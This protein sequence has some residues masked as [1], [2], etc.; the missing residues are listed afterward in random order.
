MRKA[1]EIAP[2]RRGSSFR[3]DV[4]RLASGT[5]IAQAISILAAPVITRLYSPQ[6]FGVAATFISITAL[7]GVIACLR[8][9]LSIVL[10]KD[11]HDAANLVA[12]SMLASLL[13][14]AI[15]SVG[16]W[17]GGESLS[18]IMPIPEVGAFL[19]LVPISVALSGANLSLNYWNSRTHNY[20]RLSVAK[21]LGSVC[22]TS[23]Q[24]G[25]GATGYASGGSMIAANLGGQ[26]VA[27]AWLSSWVLKAD[28]RFF[29]NSVS[30]R[31]IGRCAIRY[32]KF[33]LLSTWSGVL[34][35]ASWQ[36][37]VLM[38]GYF[39]SPVVVG[40][41]ALGF[42]LLQIPMNLMGGAVSQVFLQRAG[43]M[44]TSDG[45]A[46]LVE[47]MF[48]RLLTVGMFPML[49]LCFAGR[50]IYLVVFGDMWAEAGTYVQLLSAWAL[51][52]FVSSPLARLF[53]VLEK[54]EL[55]LAL[56]VSI[57]LTRLVSLLIGGYFESIYLALSLF[58]A[59]GFLLYGVQIIFVF[60]SVGIPVIRIWKY[61]LRNLVY[62][63]PL[64]VVLA[65]L[66]LLDAASWIV[67][68]ISGI[69]L[70][71]FGAWVLK[72]EIGVNPANR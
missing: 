25:L 44:R 22:T 54:H 42:R 9:E 69:A 8:Y 39:F 26:T 49:T 61:V 50:D 20:F 37:P 59:T 70:L 63:S 24:V 32:G 48:R 29:L 33:P 51:V 17:I 16:I 11:D 62:F 23:T 55:S 27:M 47:G 41:Y 10:P 19:W 65:V 53:F 21:V 3:G 71:I 68:S 2:R 60:R 14:S 18:R 15:S 43:E 40:Y 66:V 67:V 35:T 57:F 7:L 30:W 38:L 72:E 1:P 64:G 52:W 12:V 58:A 28:G 56:N 31:S 5:G 6:A 4:L 45:F 34:N 13:L 46:P 36:I